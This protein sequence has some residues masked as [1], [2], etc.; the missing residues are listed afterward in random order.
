MINRW[1]P[2]YIKIVVF[3]KFVE[4][5]HA[6]FIGIPCICSRILFT[7]TYTTSLVVPVPIRILFANSIQR[8]KS[9]VVFGADTETFRSLEKRLGNKENPLNNQD[10]IFYFSSETAS[11]V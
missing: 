6:V 8:R 5:G 3:T 9:S 4:G 10:M 2:T 1:R 7:C 11:M